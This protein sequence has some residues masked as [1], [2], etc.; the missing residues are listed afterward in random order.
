MGNEEHWVYEFGD[1]RL[2]L[3]RRSLSRRS[4][5]TLVLTA[6]AFD[7]LVVL[8][9][10]AGRVVTRD[11]LIRALW[12]SAVVEEN[13]LN[14]AISVLRRAL[15]P[16]LIATVTR[17]GYQ[18]VANVRRIHSTGMASSSHEL[19]AV[20][21]SRRINPLTAFLVAAMATA[22][23]FAAVYWSWRSDNDSPL[24]ESYAF[25]KLTEFDGAEDQ[26]V[27]SPDGRFAAFLRERDGVWD[28]WLG[29]VDTG[30]F[31]QLT[32]STMRELRN[33]AVRTLNFS[34]D[35][36]HVVVW[37]RTANGSAGKVDGGWV[38]PVV[39]GELRPLFR[40]IV[41]LDWSADGQRIAYHTAAAGDPL[42]VGEAGAVEQSQQIFVARSGVHNHYP[43][44]SRDGKS[45]YFVSGLIPNEMDVWRIGAD[46]SNPEQLTR[47]G[48]RVASP[49]WLT[50]RLLLY[51]ATD[52][53][54][55][56][57]WLH[58]LDVVTRRVRRIDT[59][60]QP[61]AA[62]SAS[63]DGRRLVG[64][65]VQ[66]SSSVWRMPL[67]S[68]PAAASHAQSVGIDAPRAA[69]P[70]FAAHAIVYR[71]PK[72][73]R[74]TLFRFENS[75]EFE[76]L[77]GA[78]SRVVA[79]PAV[80]RDGLTLAFTVQRNKSIALQIVHIDGSGLR[81]LAT[82]LDVRGAPAF[83]PDGRWVAIAAIRDGVPRL[84]KVSLDGDAILPLGDAYALD[85]AWA[86][87]GKFIVYSGVDIGTNFKLGAVTADGAPYPIP[88][89]TLSRGSRRIDFLADDRLVLL[90]GNLSR[91][92]L[93]AIDL[94]TAQDQPLTA[95][96][97][98][99]M[100]SDFHVSPGGLEIVFDRIRE[101]SDVMLIEAAD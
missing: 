45:V 74:E 39:G 46:G 42:F 77:S 40:G 30:D 21:R 38:V 86:P 5:E 52:A 20:K 23:V 32:A 1:F 63:R 68:V 88:P 34:P 4:G 82:S 99:T 16:N 85:P 98:N 54:G 58:E 83:S 31:R 66:Y 53:E 76:V 57:P 43:L 18:L 67:A 89:I 96:D 28:A 6:K 7:A 8:V 22:A 49:T 37:T 2:D 71:A 95:F 9:E 44:W 79:G 48:S 70:R 13:N 93:W 17:R 73:G 29:Q 12:P 92:E 87:N 91:N 26:A 24:L 56:G 25:R 51:V 84:Y 72:A 36:T 60:G 10:N 75:R 62:I 97:S 94:A 15:G 3:P 100:I 11:E 61:Y 47:H 33:P 78:D 55:S 80:S 35:S 65:A 90:R 69:A 81:S 64:S 101:T 19:A 50:D 14:Q 59:N 27:I 41:E